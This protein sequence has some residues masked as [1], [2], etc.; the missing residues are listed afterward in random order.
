MS[1]ALTL[2][3][4]VAILG[5]A[6][7]G[8]MLDL[9]GRRLTALVYFTLG[10]LSAWVCFTATEAW[11]ITAAYATVLAMHALWPIAATITSEIFP[12]AI[13][14]TANGLVNNL[15]GRTGMVLAPAVVGGLSAALGSVGSAVAW[16]SLLP[17][18]ILPI[19]LWLVSE[20]RGQ[21][22]ERIAS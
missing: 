15:L 8:P 20:T 17:L 21:E 2:G 16:V 22:L 1:Y 5:Y 3:Y 9:A 12:T 19:I 11:L 10:A 13:R 6:T 18:A 14:G 4:G 7:A